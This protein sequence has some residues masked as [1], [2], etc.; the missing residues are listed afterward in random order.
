MIPLKRLE[1]PRVLS[2]NE[3]RW[4]AKYLEERAKSPKKRP[5]HARYAHREVVA[6]LEAMSCHKCFYCEQSTKQCE[7]EVDHYIEVAERPELAFAWSN[8]Y[9]SCAGCNRKVPNS[10][11]PAADCVD[12]CDPA[13][14]PAEHLTYDDEFIRSRNSST[15][16]LRTIQKY[17]LDRPELD[18][19]RGRQLRLFLKAVIAIQEAMIAEGRRPMNDDEKELLRS[20]RQPDQP[21]SLMFVVY[22]NAMAL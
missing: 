17:R 14:L 10:S 3:E 1:E 5:P 18:L 8:L 4:R 13:A 19:K 16:G 11:I 12:P 2:E 9:L 15:R 22:T 7:K 6:T 20:F 21:F